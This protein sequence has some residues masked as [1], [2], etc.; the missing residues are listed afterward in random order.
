M[1]SR[2]IL[3]SWTPP[4][5]HEQNGAIRHYVLNVTEAETRRAF[6]LISYAT[7]EA[8]HSLHPHYTYQLRVAAVTIGLG[9]FSPEV[10]ITTPQ[11][12]KGLPRHACH[13][14]SVPKVN[15]VNL[16]YFLLRIKNCIRLVGS[17]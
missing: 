11:D 15:P 16:K 13:T 9:P 14:I 2:S 7:S 12:G 4:T 5:Q 8:L 6:Q 17:L 1:D 10:T 3:V